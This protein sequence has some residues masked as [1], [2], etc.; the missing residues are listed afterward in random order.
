MKIAKPKETNGWLDNYI[1]EVPGEDLLAMLE[2]QRKSSM[3]F[4]AGMSNDQLAFRYA[5]GKWTPQEIFA[6]LLD[7]ERVFAY[8][9][10]RFAR[11]D[12]T[13]LPGY[14]EQLYTTTAKANSRAITSMV[15]EYDGLRQSTILLFGSFDEDML[16]ERGNAN[17][18][19]MSVSA[20]GYAILGHELHHLRIICER[21]LNEFSPSAA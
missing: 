7:T 15:S 18:T 10:M 12:K 9:A 21:Y 20:L 17:N 2:A 14:D 13:V 8:R 11:K 4:F 19:E 5:A 1:A 16:A 6:H 3:T